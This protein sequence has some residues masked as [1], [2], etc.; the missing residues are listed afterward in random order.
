[1]FLCQ[2]LAEYK[3]RAADH[4]LTSYPALWH[5]IIQFSCHLL[6]TSLNQSV[7]T[8]V[9]CVFVNTTVSFSSDYGLASIAKTAY[10]IGDNYRLASIM[11]YYSFDAA[12]YNISYLFRESDKAIIVK[13]PELKGKSLAIS[14]LLTFRKEA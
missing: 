9:R 3:C 4:D 14:F 2:L 10:S 7:E 6:L 12:V 1:M 8:K 11:P 5:F 13:C